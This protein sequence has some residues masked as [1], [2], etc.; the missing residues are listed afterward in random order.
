MLNANGEN[1]HRIAFIS[2]ADWPPAWEAAPFVFLECGGEMML[3]L[4]SDAIT[5]RM[6]E[7]C[8]ATFREMPAAS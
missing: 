7:D 5:P 8:W 1:H 6:L 2:E 3:A 4:K